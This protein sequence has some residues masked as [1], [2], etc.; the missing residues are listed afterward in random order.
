[1]RFRL[2]R[3]ECD[4]DFALTGCDRASDVL[5]HRR[6]GHPGVKTLSKVSGIKVHNSD[7]TIM[8]CDVCVKAKQ[9]KNPYNTERRRAEHLLQI[10]HTDM[11]GLMNNSNSII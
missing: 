4:D 7:L 8:T 2:V 1:M 3:D 10:I 5:W 9:I 11:T 6:L